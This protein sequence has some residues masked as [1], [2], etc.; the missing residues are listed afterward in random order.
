MPPEPSTPKVTQLTATTTRLAGRGAGAGT[1]AVDLLAAA[2]SDGFLWHH[3]EFG[4]A[5]RG[6]ALRIELPGGLADSAAVAGASGTLA[7]IARGDDLAGPGTGAVAFGAL[8]FG[9]DVP[10]F[11]ADDP[12]Q[13]TQI[14]FA[15]PHW[16]GHDAPLSPG[17][18]TLPRQQR[19]RHTQNVGWRLH[20][21]PTHTG[22]TSSR[23]LTSGGLS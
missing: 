20:R 1:D 23:N 17:D 18:P 15:G 6:A 22:T 3:E 8:P 12:G 11:P 5:G 19:P 2:G 9:R 10:A 4:L 21:G 13:G 7:A 16:D 14:A